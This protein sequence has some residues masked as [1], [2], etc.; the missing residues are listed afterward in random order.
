MEYTL[1]EHKELHDSLNNPVSDCEHCKYETYR[2]THRCFGDGGSTVSL[3]Q[4]NNKYVS[5]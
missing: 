2:R 1:E 4:P 5:Y 3:P